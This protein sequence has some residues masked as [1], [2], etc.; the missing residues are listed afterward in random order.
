MEDVKHGGCHDCGSKLQ[1]VLKSI[2]N[3]ATPLMGKAV[4]DGCLKK[5]K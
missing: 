4:C 3:P 5:Q 2:E 1:E